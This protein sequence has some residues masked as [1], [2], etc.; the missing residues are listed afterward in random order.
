MAVTGRRVRA[1]EALSAT[2]RRAVEALP[3]IGNPLA[4]GPGHV[5]V[6]DLPGSPEA[7]EALLGATGADDPRV[8]AAW[9]VHGHAWRSA[10]PAIACLALGGRAPDAGPQNV[11][12]HVDAGVAR[13]RLVDPERDVGG[14]VGLRESLAANMAVVVALPE[15]ACLG[16]RARWSL[17][18]DAVVGAALYVGLRLAGSAEAVRLAMVMAGAGPMAVPLGLIDPA[19]PGEDGIARRRASCC[20][21][22]REGLD[23]CPGCPRRVPRRGQRRG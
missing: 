8:R 9:L 6:A 10:A 12:L 17:A 4:G 18:G 22:H 20:L 14:P 2:L 13:L 21:A 23:L 7:V 3:E 19:P 11:G 1:P 16:A 15:L 5:R